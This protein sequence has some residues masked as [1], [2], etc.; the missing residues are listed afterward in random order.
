MGRSS[1][2]YF[3]GSPLQKAALNRGLV[4][5]GS[6]RSSRLV[7]LQEERD[8]L[9]ERLTVKGQHN[10]GLVLL[11]IGVASHLTPKNNVL[12]KVIK[13]HHRNEK[14]NENDHNDQ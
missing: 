14:S 4:Q 1:D 13:Q 2:S 3:N 6:A 5:H 11:S 12:V 10:P 7:P 8:E 9:P